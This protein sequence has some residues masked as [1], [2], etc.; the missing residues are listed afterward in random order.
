[1]TLDPKPVPRFVAD[2][3][4]YGLP[5]GR[6]AARLSESFIEACAAIDDLPE[7]TPMP[8]EIVWYPERTFSGRTYSPATAY[9]EAVM[10]D[11]AEP[12]RIEFFGY[13]SY[14][15]PEDGDP[16]DF[17]STADFTDVTAADNP[18]WKVDLND[19]VIGEWNGERGRHADV[20]LVWGRIL[21][22]GSYAVSA[23]I[24]EI[25]V[26]QD[27][28][29]G[30]RFTLIAPDALKNFGDDAFL[31]VRVWTERGRE[32]AVESLYEE[33]EAEPE[34]PAGDDSGKG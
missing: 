8:T 22:D 20:T 17:T 16:H 32:L 33:P 23:E 24:A 29:F 5:D 3:C 11:G 14:L 13:V 27:P 30:D 6:F 15:Q 34:E 10:E 2:A 12:A 4:R 1:M 7:G 26:D 18:E 21:I 9:G 31:E 25:T 19:E 28:V